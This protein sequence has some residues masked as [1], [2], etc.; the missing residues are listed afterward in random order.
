MEALL[1]YWCWPFDAFPSYLLRLHPKFGYRKPWTQWPGYLTPWGGF[2]YCIDVGLSLWECTCSLSHWNLWAFPVGLEDMSEWKRLSY[3]FF[4][5]FP[6]A[7]TKTLSIIWYLPIPWNSFINLPEFFNSTDT[8]SC[9]RCKLRCLVLGYVALSHETAFKITSI[10][11][12]NTDHLVYQII[13][14]KKYRSL[15]LRARD[16]PMFLAQTLNLDFS[17][18]CHFLWYFLNA[19]SSVLIS[20]WNAKYFNSHPHLDTQSISGIYWDEKVVPFQPAILNGLHLI[21]V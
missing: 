19:S 2:G 13:D 14:E 12:P 6:T 9:L 1:G 5:Y 11:G 4:R 3:H 7:K 16:V 17:T 8:Y 18:C 21:F 10:P 20:L 15:L